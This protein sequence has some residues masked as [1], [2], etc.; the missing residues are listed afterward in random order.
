VPAFTLGC[1]ATHRPPFLQKLGIH[2]AL[3]KVLLGEVNIRSPR[4]TDTISYSIII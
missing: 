4:L 1:T 3:Q 2:V